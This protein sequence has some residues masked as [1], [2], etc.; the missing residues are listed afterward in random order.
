MAPQRPRH[1]PESGKKRHTG[2]RRTQPDAPADV[3][4]T[5]L[6]EHTRNGFQFRRGVAVEG[7]IADFH[8]GAAKLAVQIV[9]AARKAERPAITKNEEALARA[10]LRVL[11][12]PVG[13]IARSPRAA[14]RL[15][16]DALMESGHA[17]GP[18]KASK[19]QFG[20]GPV[21]DLWGPQQ[22]LVGPAR[23]RQA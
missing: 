7:G 10:G 3:L 12:V 16:A 15:V 18:A 9:G 8:C 5:L 19:H 17:P 20:P 22:A 1:R 6:R 14:A 13:V 21:G 11:R 4:W 2:V 23:Y